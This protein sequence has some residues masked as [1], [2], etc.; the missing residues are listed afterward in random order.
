MISFTSNSENPDGADWHHIGIGPGSIIEYCIIEYSRAALGIDGDNVIISNNIIR[1]NLWTALTIGENGT[2]IVSNNIIYDS[3]GH[4][5]IVTFGDAIIENNEIKNCKG[6]ISVFN[7][8]SPTIRNNTLIDNDAGIG[9][10]E[11]STATVEG[12][13]VSSPNGGQYDWNYKGETIYFASTIEKDYGNVT[14][15]N[16]G[17]SSPIITNNILENCA[18]IIGI[19]GNSSPVI[20]HNIIRY[21]RDNGIFFEESFEG[22]PQIYENNLDNQNNIGMSSSTSIDASNNWWGTAD[23][24][25]IE[26]RISHYND[27]PSRGMVSF[28]PFLTQPVDLG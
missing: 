4:Q 7:N 2:A 14:G 8:S 17:S 16:I 21:G 13:I 22:S 28:E 20:T 1:H 6:G 9:I 24:Q 11:N 26:D 23:L 15:I 18:N 19:T 5:G 25:E 27:D 3:G 10:G 12:N